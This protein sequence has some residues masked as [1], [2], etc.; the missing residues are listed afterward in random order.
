MSSGPDSAIVQN[1]ILWMK[2]SFI[3]LM[4]KRLKLVSQLLYWIIKC[5]KVFIVGGADRL[6]WKW[7]KEKNNIQTSQELQMLPQGYIL[8]Y[9]NSLNVRKGF[10]K[11]RGKYSKK[12][13]SGTLHLEKTTITVTKIT[14]NQWCST[15][16]CDQW[17]TPFLKCVVSMRALPVR[18]VG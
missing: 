11:Q 8:L 18:G 13:F 4:T 2:K 6:L 9:R 1:S 15:L 14:H 5:Q 16:W 10:P 7:K 3:L 17:G 12:S